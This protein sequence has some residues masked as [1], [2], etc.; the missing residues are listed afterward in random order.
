MSGG[1]DDFTN[2]K[3]REKAAGNLAGAQG[4]D[5]AIATTALQNAPATG[6]PAEIGMHAPDEVKGMALFPDHTAILNASPEVASFTASDPA[7]AAATQDDL[8]N[9]AGVAIHTN[10][11]AAIAAMDFLNPGVSAAR[12]LFTDIKRDYDMTGKDKPTML[13]LIP[14]FSP[15]DKR[16]GSILG[17]VA[18]V[19]FTLPSGAVNVAARPFSY[20]PGADKETTF[21]NGNAV[22]STLSQQQTQQ[23]IAGMFGTAL[24][25]VMPEKGKAPPI[26]LGNAS[27]VSDMPRLPGPTEPVQDAQF[28]DIKP[29]GVRP[30][31][32]DSYHAIAELDAENINRLQTSL[33][34]TKTL[35]RAPELAQDFL[36]NHTP[37]GDTTVSVPAESI[38]KLWDAGHEVFTD[39]AD[40]I[41][42]ALVLGS[43][44]RIPLAQ[45][46]TETAGKPFQE[47]LNNATRFRD[48][49][50]LAR[51]SE[52]P[53][54]G[55]RRF[56]HR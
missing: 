55:S 19:A 38:T 26:D 27:V 50:H 15:Q 11:W 9:F 43:E 46:L 44:V 7:K 14:G 37:V 36:Q 25:A 34:E 45:Y 39:H 4:V 54:Q 29:P 51:S 32:N 13:G 30:E 1:W 33:T 12:Q 35:G 24:M 53:A 31:D 28:T 56:R 20:I 18:G 16:L 17:D 2:T 10:N 40:A 21:K 3:L 48:R 5:P 6:V 8:H 22:T 52:G 49:R 41:N 23:K 47:E 42:S